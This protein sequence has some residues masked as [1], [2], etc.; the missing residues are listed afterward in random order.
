[1]T[2][3]RTQPVA[4]T[5]VADAELAV[6]KVLWD[7]GPGVVREIQ[8][9]LVAGERER[10]YAYTTVQTL[11]QRLCDKG[12]VQKDARGHAHVYRA[13]VTR[14]QHASARVGDVVDSVL[15]GALAPL[16]LG[17]LPQGR[18]TADEIAR[19]RE[20]LDAAEQQAGGRPRR[21]KGGP[22]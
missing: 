4:A 15:D 9:R 10:D 2:P 17:L 13:A 21:G 22:A 1:M 16:L 8:E 7:G 12:L 18:F 3:R 5:A 6:L 19:F 11:L 20:L 14:E